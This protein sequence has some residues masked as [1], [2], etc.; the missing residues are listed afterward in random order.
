MSRKTIIIVCHCLSR[1]ECHRMGKRLME[2]EKPIVCAR[3]RVLGIETDHGIWW[4]ECG[5]WHKWWKTDLFKWFD[6][7]CRNFC[8]IFIGCHL[9]VCSCT[10]SPKTERFCSL[11]A[12]I[13]TRNHPAQKIIGRTRWYCRDSSHQREASKATISVIGK[14][15]SAGSKM[16]EA[17]GC[18]DNFFPN[19]LKLKSSKMISSVQVRHCPVD[20]TETRQNDNIFHC[21]LTEHY[22]PYLAQ[23]KKTMFIAFLRPIDESLCGTIS[24]SYEPGSVAGIRWIFVRKIKHIAAKVK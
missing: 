24:I 5:C 19:R 14:R 6:I 10:S 1:G 21:A 12:P 16:E 18:M 7:V 2:I 9:Y 22:P 23:T 3:T 8:N 11:T 4:Y 20:T 17:S 13:R 15:H